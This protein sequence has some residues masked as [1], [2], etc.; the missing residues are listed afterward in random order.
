VGAPS[1]VYVPYEQDANWNGMTLAVRTNGE[2]TSFA[3]AIRNEIKAID[4]LTP[5]YNVKTM[6]DV[7]AKSSASRRVPMLLLTAFAAVAMLLA[8]LGIYGITAYY[9]SQR[10]H[11]IGIRMALGAQIS[12]VL[13]LV[14]RRGVYFSVAGIVVGIV[15]AIALTRYLATLLFGIGTIHIATFGAVSLVLVAVALLACYIP[16]RRATKVDPLEALRYE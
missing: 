16:A 5:I 2:P 6:D 3:P 13:K 9:V 15:G 11:E 4:K 14:L 7:M 8:M 10:T 12:D 1:F